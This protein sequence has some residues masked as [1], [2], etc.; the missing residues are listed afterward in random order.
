MSAPAPNVA[1]AGHDPKN[2]PA[3]Q[4]PRTERYLSKTQRTEIQ[5]DIASAD[6]FLNHPQTHLRPQ[7]PN[8]VR[9]QIINLNQMLVKGTPPPLSGRNLDAAV[10]RR[11]ELQT[12]IAGTLQ[13]DEEMRKNPPG[14]VGRYQRGEASP[15]CKADIL[16][17]KNLQEAI[18]P[19]SDDPDKC[20]VEMLRQWRR[21]SDLNMDGAQITGKT[22]S[23]PSRLYEQNYEQV[24][25]P[26]HASNIQSAMEQEPT[27]QGGLTN[28][29]YGSVDQ[30][31]ER[32]AATIR[33][34][35]SQLSG[36]NKD[37]THK[38][39]SAPDR[40]GTVWTD[41]MR[42]HQADKARQQHARRRERE[43][44]EAKAAAE[45]AATVVEEKV[46]EPMIAEDIASVLADAEER[47][48]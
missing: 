29:Q 33:S 10:G 44:E 1:P 32:L 24:F 40:P 16:E 22:H 4:A 13:S 25:G 34:A 31:R 30:Q 18:H 20:N 45:V 5:Q 3:A 38:A 27:Y 11:D 2:D 28:E 12:R 19:E 41:E 23:V 7:V 36:L 37:A 48:E 17:W 42:A 35:Q 9:R 6:N 43:A 21:P 39:L 46:V 47:E 26:K 14:A 8:D 15:R